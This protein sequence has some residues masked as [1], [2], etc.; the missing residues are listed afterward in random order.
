MMES[1]LKDLKHSLR[2][3]LQN[4]SFTITALAAI[5]LGIGTNTAIF[6]V[7]NAVL[8]KPVRAPE[9]DRV[10]VFLATNKEGTS[11]DASEIKFNLWR[12]QTS[13]F[14]DVSGYYLGFVNL[15]GVEQP[16]RANAI[17]VTQDYFHLFGLRFAQGRGFTAEEERPNGAA[18]V[19][20]SDAFWKR[21]FGA[22]PRI[23]GNTISLSGTT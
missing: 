23:V 12:E 6:S 3:F 9:P 11:S 5:A 7:V 16:Q 18:A 20:L 21:A 14:R 8:L 17:F 15:T 13:V 19:V 10:V 2:G 4:P 22:D 1:L